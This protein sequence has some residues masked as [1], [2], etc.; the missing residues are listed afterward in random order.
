MHKLEV[1]RGPTV[2][3]DS[4]VGDL[5]TRELR[6]ADRGPVDYDSSLRAQTKVLS[7]CAWLCR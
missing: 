5:A 1:S 2:H 3:V 7:W 4:I 6:I